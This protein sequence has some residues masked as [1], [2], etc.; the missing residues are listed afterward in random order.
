MRFSWWFNSN[1]LCISGYDFFGMYWFGQF[2]INSILLQFF[3]L[4]PLCF[5]W[6]LCKMFIVF[7]LRINSLILIYF[8]QTL[9]ATVLNNGDFELL[10]NANLRLCIP[11]LFKDRWALKWSFPNILTLYTETMRTGFGPLL[12]KDLWELLHPVLYV[13]ESI[14]CEW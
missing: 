14:L 13:H 1:L 11:V 9:A 2:W 8:K 4:I 5:F 6:F 10:S 12:T 7:H 3:I